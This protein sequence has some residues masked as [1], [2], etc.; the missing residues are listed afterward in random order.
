MA[1]TE[2]IQRDLPVPFSSLFWGRYAFDAARELGLPNEQSGGRLDDLGGHQEK[3]LCSG[4]ITASGAK[5][6]GTRTVSRSTI[7]LKTAPEKY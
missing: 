5:A 2:T 4:R 1:S 6:S 7:L 3:F